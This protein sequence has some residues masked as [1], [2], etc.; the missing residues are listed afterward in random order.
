MTA[1]CCGCHGNF[2]IEQADTGAW[3]RHPSDAVIPITGEYVGYATYNPQAP[4]ARPSLTDW[5]GPNSL[6]NEGGTVEKDMV[7]CLSCHRAH[8]SPYSDLLR[9]DYQ[10]MIARDNTKTGGCFVCHTSKNSI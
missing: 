10:E 2:H 6:V 3:I 8:G 4:V 9:W 7:M 5:T 1:F